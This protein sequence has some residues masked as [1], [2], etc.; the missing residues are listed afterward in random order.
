[1]KTLPCTDLECKSDHRAWGP[2]RIRYICSIGGYFVFRKYL[3]SF[4][5][6]EVSVDVY[7]VK[8]FESVL[9]QFP[10]YNLPQPDLVTGRAATKPP[11]EVPAPAEHPQ[12]PTL[13]E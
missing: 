2:D 12:Y 13:E 6:Q 7:D 4:W 8:A 1:M 9:G 11:R 5:P 3:E 10:R